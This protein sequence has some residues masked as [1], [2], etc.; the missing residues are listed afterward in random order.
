M[1]DKVRHDIGYAS[2][3]WGNRVQNRLTRQFEKAHLKLN[4]HTIKNISIPLI[5]WLARALSMVN[6]PDILNTEVW[7][8]Q[9]PTCPTKVSLSKIIALR[10]KDMDVKD[11]YLRYLGSLE[12]AQWQP[13]GYRRHGVRSVELSWPSSLLR[14]PESFRKFVHQWMRLAEQSLIIYHVSKASTANPALYI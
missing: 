8:L 10:M 5:V 7:F 2:T 14:T 11:E 6:L 9:R 12:I 1:F 13:A 3:A 4:R